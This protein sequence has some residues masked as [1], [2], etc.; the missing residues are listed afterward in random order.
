MKC[1]VSGATG[2]I[3]RQLCQQLAASGHVVVAL[4][5]CG[6]PLAGGL[7]TIAVDLARSAPDDALL[8]GVDVVFHLAGIAH[9]RAPESDYNALNCSG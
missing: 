1:L 3:G 5:K 9:Q 2:F 4:S 7:P 6:E 8:Q